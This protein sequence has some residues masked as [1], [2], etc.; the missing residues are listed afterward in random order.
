MVLFIRIPPIH[1]PKSFSPARIPHPTE[2]TSK[3]PTTCMLCAMVALYSSSMG[4]LALAAQNPYMYRAVPSRSPTPRTAGQML[5]Q[6][7]TKTLSPAGT[8]RQ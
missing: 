4:I 7:A 2:S 8:K 6:G 5:R 1:S 3:R